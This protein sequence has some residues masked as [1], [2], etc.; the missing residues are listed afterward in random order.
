VKT[1]SCASRTPTV[2]PRP[3]ERARRPATPKARWF[4]A[5]RPDAAAAARLGALAARLAASLGG[6][7]LAADDIHLTLVFVG[8]RPAADEPSLAGVLAGID[9]GW[10]ALALTRLGSFGRGLYWVGPAHPQGATAGGAT[11][12]S[13]PPFPIDSPGSAESSSSPGSP[14]PPGSPPW[15]AALAAQLQQRLREAGI[16]FDERTLH[17]HATLLRGARRDVRPRLETFA[18]ALPLESSCWTLTL[19]CSDAGSTPQRRYRWREAR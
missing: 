9:S 11:D 15:P 4:Y 13:A 18:D 10:P 14:A 19:G 6:R 8:E 17:L 5:L 12:G 2:A 7:P 1:T 3:P 16:A